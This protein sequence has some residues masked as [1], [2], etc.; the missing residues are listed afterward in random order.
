MTLSRGW[1]LY[2]KCF[3]VEVASWMAYRLNFFLFLIG[4]SIFS[5]FGPVLVYLI[6]SNNLSFPGWTF[7]EALLLLGSFSLVS[8]IEHYA[9]SSIGW[10]THELIR[11]GRFDEMLIRPY[12]PLKLVILRNPDVDGLA[13]L[14][15]GLAIV[16]Y[17]LVKLQLVLQPTYIL[18]Y[19][20]LVLAGVVFLTSIDIMA[21]SMNFIFVKAHAILDFFTELRMFGRYP[22]NIFGPMGYMIF[23]FFLPMGL[24]AFYPSSALLGRVAWS[25][26]L[27]LIL[28][29]TGFLLFSLLSWRYGIK[30]YTSAGG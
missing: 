22:I 30:R 3:L 1:K 28:I 16:I 18:M 20:V 7:Y 13:E 14:F 10:A 24:I 26:V 4:V 6:Y 17:A 19:I 12:S 8:G 15:T 21:S 11:R 2:K 27:Q 23:T 25:S 5:L 29:S 9:F